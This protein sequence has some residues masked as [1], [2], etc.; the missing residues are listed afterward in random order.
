MGRT[1]I[2]LAG[3]DF[4]KGKVDKVCMTRSRKAQVIKS[5]SLVP[6][7]FIFLKILFDGLP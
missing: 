5:F 2:V 7:M 6:R 1:K 3:V 4:N